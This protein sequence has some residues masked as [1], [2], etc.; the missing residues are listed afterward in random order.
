M[1]A[2]PGDVIKIHGD[3]SHV[4]RMGQIIGVEEAFGHEHLIVEWEDGHTSLY[5]PH[6]GVTIIHRSSPA[7]RDLAPTTP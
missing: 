3:R 4:A 6:E 7:R 2:Q 5:I 1:R